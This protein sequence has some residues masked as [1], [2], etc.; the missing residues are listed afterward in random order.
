M[1]I[2][3]RRD[4]TGNKIGEERLILWSYGSRKRK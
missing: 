4:K 2:I 3:Q 1:D